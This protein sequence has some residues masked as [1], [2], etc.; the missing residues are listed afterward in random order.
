MRAATAASLL[1]AEGRAVVAVDDGFEGAR[2]AGLTVTRNAG[3]TGGP[4]A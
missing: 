3:G 2:R 4:G 1:D